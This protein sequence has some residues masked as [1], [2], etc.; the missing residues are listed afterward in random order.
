VVSFQR[1]GPE[2]LTRVLP[3]KLARCLVVQSEAAK[4]IN[5]LYPNKIRCIRKVR[6]HL[7]L[8][9]GPS[10]VLFVRRENSR[11]LS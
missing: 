9:R 2:S 11:N 7:K 8:N 4:Q 3:K 6:L 1:L 10:N 5:Q